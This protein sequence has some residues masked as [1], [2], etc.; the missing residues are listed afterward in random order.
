MAKTTLVDRHQDLPATDY[1]DKY[2]GE[3]THVAAEHSVTPRISIL[4]GATPQVK[5]NN[6]AYV[7]GA[8]PGMI[9]LSSYHAPL[10]DGEEGII[11]QPCLLQTP[12]EVRTPRESGAANFVGMFATPQPDWTERHDPKG[13]TYYTTRDG[14]IA[15][16]VHIQI[17]LLHIDGN[18]LPYAIKFAGTGIFI[19][20]QWN[21]VI[22][23][24]RTN[25]NLEAPRFAFTYRMR[26][27]SQANAAGEWGQWSISAHGRSSEAEMDA[28]H[29]LREAFLKGEAR[30]EDEQPG[31]ATQSGEVM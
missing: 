4:Q 29:D 22:S 24:R 8:Q 20:K 30:V 21:S 25:T 19:S 15:H 11:F 14:N 23:T 26:V 18:V 1:A 9:F 12:W 31:E 10:I 28:G 16:Q 7:E 2:A 17:G 13:F 3:G 5:R 6:V 27:K